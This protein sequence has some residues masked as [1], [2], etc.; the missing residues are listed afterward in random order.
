M[1]NYT[2]S[3]EL[4][5]ANH[6]TGARNFWRRK[7]FA[8]NKIATSIAECSNTCFLWNSELFL[9]RQSVTLNFWIC[10]FCIIFSFLS[11]EW[12]S[13]QT[14]LNFRQ[15][16]NKEFDVE[17]EVRNMPPFV[18]KL[19]CLWWVYLNCSIFS[20]CLIDFASLKY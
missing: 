7:E 19:S 14:N 2:S 8:W 17:K 20:A 10:L 1:K 11:C 3:R 6:L 15:M 4:H 13:H 18:R 12:V 9:Q 5:L 16:S